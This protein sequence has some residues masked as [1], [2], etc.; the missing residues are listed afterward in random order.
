MQRR[1]H[2]EARSVDAGA[3]E[4]EDPNHADSA[5]RMMMLRR[6]RSRRASRAAATHRDVAPVTPYTEEQARAI[7]A[8]WGAVPLPPALLATALW[9]HASP[10][11]WAVVAE[12]YGK[13]YA[14]ELASATERAGAAERAA[15]ERA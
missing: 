12:R 13:E 7:V 5:R 2:P 1:H 3:T 11:L 8:T 4:H 14:S 10:A 6:A 15:A 9:T